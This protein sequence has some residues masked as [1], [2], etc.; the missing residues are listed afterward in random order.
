MLLARRKRKGGETCGQI[1]YPD[2]SQVF[3]DER[4][5]ILVE[6]CGCADGYSGDRNNCV[7]CQMDSG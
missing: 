7:L 3:S 6:D 2:E 1:R 5:R 4:P